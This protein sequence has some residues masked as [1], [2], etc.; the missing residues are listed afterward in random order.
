MKRALIVLALMLLSRAVPSRGTDNPATNSGRR[1]GNAQYVS[2]QRLFG[3][4]AR[5]T[6]LHVLP[7]AAQ[8]HR[9]HHATVEPNTFQQSYTLYTS[10]TSSSREHNPRWESPAACV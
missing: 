4:H 8:R 5:R 9:R 7:C 2:R 10:T 3:N 1:S 6:R